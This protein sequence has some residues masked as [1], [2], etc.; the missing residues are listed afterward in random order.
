MIPT[1]QQVCNLVRRILGD[2]QISGGQIF[3]NQFLYGAPAGATAPFNV[4]LVAGSPMESGYNK[5]FE[6]MRTIMDRR[7]RRTSFAFVPQFTSFLNPLTAGISNCGNPIN[8][9]ERA[10]ATPPYYDI[11]AITLTPASQG[12]A[13]SALITVN[14]GGTLITGQT[15]EIQ[16]VQGISDDINNYWTLTVPDTTHIQLNGCTALGTYTAST[17]I[18][19]V[20][21]EAWPQTPMQR[22]WNQFNFNQIQPGPA[23]QTCFLNWTWETSAIRLPP[24]AAARE[25]MIDYNLSGQVPLDPSLSLGIDDILNSM[26]YRVAAIAGRSKGRPQD[27]CDGYLQ[28]SDNFFKEFLQPVTKDLQRERLIVPRYRGKRNTGWNIPY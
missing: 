9:W 2:T 25:L 5:L 22:V 3:T 21:S 26:A 4:D 8:L 19:I 18:V 15:I 7:C 28:E 11:T 17:G 10:L 27:A 14:H 1:G 6:R 16:G 13:P 12:V 24:L 20:G 23:T